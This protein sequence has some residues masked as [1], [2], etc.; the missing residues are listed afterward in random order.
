M[1]INEFRAFFGPVPVPTSKPGE[2]TVAEQGR[3]VS[4]RGKGWRVE[5]VDD[6]LEEARNHGLDPGPQ[7]LDGLTI[8]RE[9]LILVNDDLG[10]VDRLEIAVHELLHAFDHSLSERRVRILGRTLAE[11]LWALGY[12]RRK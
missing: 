4:V 12:R 5:Y 9:R 10:G 8:F 1:P 3:D 2:K 7:E 11:C 6:V